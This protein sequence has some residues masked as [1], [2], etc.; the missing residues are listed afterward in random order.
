MTIASVTAANAPQQPKKDGLA[1]LGQGDFLKLMLTQ[2]KNQDPT[3]P[4]DQ[5]EMLAQMAQFTSLSGI[6][7]MGDTLKQIAAKLD[8][9]HAAQMAANPPANS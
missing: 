1:G 4:V 5:K 2:L 8:A 6:S 9:I 3:D 7:E